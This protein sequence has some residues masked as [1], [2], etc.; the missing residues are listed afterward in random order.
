MET[1]SNKPVKPGQQAERTFFKGETVAVLTDEEAKAMIATAIEQA[2]YELLLRKVALAAGGAMKSRA[3]WWEQF[4]KKHNLN[5]EDD[6]FEYVPEKD[7][8]PAHV[9][10][11]GKA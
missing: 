7:G 2:G 1:K 8:Q 4:G 6:V 11:T 10:Y 3:E 5:M 9:I